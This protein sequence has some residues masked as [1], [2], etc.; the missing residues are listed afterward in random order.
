MLYD[1]P[2]DFW[3]GKFSTQKKHIITQVFIIYMLKQ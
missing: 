3:E 2:F 1:H